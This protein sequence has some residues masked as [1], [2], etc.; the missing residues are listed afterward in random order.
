VQRV[1]HV[2]SA[3]RDSRRRPRESA[4][5]VGILAEEAGRRGRPSTAEICIIKGER[6]DPRFGCR[7]PG[8][9]GPG[10][11]SATYSLPKPLI[12]ITPTTTPPPPTTAT[13]SLSYRPV[14][15]AVVDVEPGPRGRRARI[16]VVSGRG[17]GQEVL[18]RGHGSL[19]WP[20]L[21]RKLASSLSSPI[22][23]LRAKKRNGG[24]SELALYTYGETEV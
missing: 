9:E 19:L 8:A 22:V 15:L 11:R 13:H 2:P 12:P 4:F 1:H 20:V 16:A 18:G 17:E 7:P 3:C 5:A 24:S 21:I 23:S 6:R 10:P 14:S